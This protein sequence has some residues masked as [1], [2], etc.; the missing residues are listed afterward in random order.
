LDGTAL[1]TSALYEALPSNTVIS[2]DNELV[3]AGS[4][5]HHPLNGKVFSYQIY[6]LGLTNEKI[7]NYVISHMKDYNFSSFF[8]NPENNNFERFFQN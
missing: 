2:S 3:I 1:P 5:A 7:H 6:N 4:D 8:N